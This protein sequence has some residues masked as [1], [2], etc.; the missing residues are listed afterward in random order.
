MCLQ[1]HGDRIRKVDIISVTG[2]GVL[3]MVM[4]NNIF[5]VRCAPNSQTLKK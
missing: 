1:T 2:Q 5:Y 3:G 4:G